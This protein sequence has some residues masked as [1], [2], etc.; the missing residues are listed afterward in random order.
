MK[1]RTLKIIFV[2]TGIIIIILLLLPGI[3]KRY[4]INSSKE[5]IGRQIQI[6]KLKYNYFTSTVK[7]YDFKILEKN[8]NDIFSSFDTLIVNLKPLSLIKDKIE[9]EQLYIKGLM[10]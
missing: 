4:A 6:D 8:G 9:I 7:V 2:I 5:L 1:K 10:V 3:A